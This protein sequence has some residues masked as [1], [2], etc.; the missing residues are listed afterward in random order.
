M[1]PE[2]KQKWI[3]ALRSGKYKQCKETLFDGVGYCCLGVLCE[4]GGLTRNE[5]IYSDEIGYKSEGELSISHLNRFGLH[6]SE[7]S[8]LID[9]N[10]DCNKNFLEI[11]DYIEANL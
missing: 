11:A 9:M 3:E 1:N 6:G 7:Q 8:H 4:I 5:S 10:D 2:Y